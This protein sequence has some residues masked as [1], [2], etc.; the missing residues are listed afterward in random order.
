MSRMYLFLLIIVLFENTRVNM[1][2]NIT[3]AGFTPSDWKQIKISKQPVS[4]I[5]FTVYSKIICDKY[6]LFVGGLIS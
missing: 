1:E 2:V 3:R 6:Q 5:W 4:L